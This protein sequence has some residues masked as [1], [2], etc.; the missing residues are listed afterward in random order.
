MFDFGFLFPHKN[1]FWISFSSSISNCGI[2]VKKA[3]YIIFEMAND[4]SLQFLWLSQHFSYCRVLRLHYYDQAQYRKLGKTFSENNNN[5]LRT[6]M[7][8]KKLC[9]ML[10]IILYSCLN[11][12]RLGYFYWIGKHK[13]NFQN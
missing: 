11:I 7:F 13:Q 4:L 8:L 5:F 10:Y 9:H 2:V 12:L 3:K 6:Y 1:N